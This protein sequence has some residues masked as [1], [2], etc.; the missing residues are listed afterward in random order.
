LTLISRDLGEPFRD[1]GNDEV[2]AI[3]TITVAPRRKEDLGGRAVRC[4]LHLRIGSSLIAR[5]SV[6]AKSSCP[7]RLGRGD[8]HRA[9]LAGL[10]F[11][12]GELTEQ[13]G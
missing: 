3:H 4:R 9:V 1:L 10:D 13:P 2:V 5:Q 8:V 11:Q 6:I 7:G 12:G